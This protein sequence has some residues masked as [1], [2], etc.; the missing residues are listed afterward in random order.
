MATKADT[1]TTYSKAETNALVSG[2]TIPWLGASDGI[3][4]VTG[5]S[6]S[7]AIHTASDQ[8]AMEILGPGTSAEGDVI[9]YGKA[10]VAGTLTTGGTDVGATL[11]SQ[12]AG[13]AEVQQVAAN[14]LQEL[15]F[16]QSGLIEVQG[17]AAA[18][19]QELGFVQSGLS[20]VQG[21]VATH[22]TQIASL[23]TDLDAKQEA[24]EQPGAGHELL[25]GGSKLKRL[26]A[27]DGLLGG[28]VQQPD[29]SEAVTLTLAPSYK[30]GVQDQ[31]LA[32][33]ASIDFVT[34]N[35]QPAILAQA[36]LQLVDNVAGIPELSIDSAVLAGKQDVLVQEGFGHELLHDGN[37]LKKLQA[38]N[39][40]SAG[41]T[42]QPDGSLV[43][44]LTLASNYTNGVQE[45]LLGKQDTLSAGSDGFV[46]GE[47]TLLSG[48]TVKSLAPGAGI[49]LE[50]F[51]QHVRISA[52]L[53]QSPFWVAGSVRAS[54]QAVMNSKG[55][56]SFTA[57]RAP[58]FSTGVFLIDWSEPHP[59]G[60][61][62]MSIVS[63]E[64]GATGTG[65]Q[66]VGDI[67]S[68]SN[69]SLGNT[70][71]RLWVL[72]RNNVGGLVDGDFNFIVL[73]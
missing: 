31:L 19:L 38:Y 25:Y 32:Q 8:L 28:T 58:G 11:S 60:Q 26:Q 29:G 4:K 10:A 47:A 23:Q 37:K 66:A 1:E 16:V 48:N 39:G 56:Y 67:H 46:P 71:T 55:R 73:A 14:T 21:T 5:G 20:E 27:E 35:Y 17:V 51:G 12:G 15:G 22:R 7:L 9:V 34:A 45:Q 53:L 69:A 59:D 68:S 70:A 2:A 63:G 61:N 6:S 18:N 62:H 49:Q 13:L 65:W 24:L 3:H 30:Q 54:D 33:Q 72:T 40:I 52:P 42:T 43:L 44:D 41:T 57:S 50:D 64:A 36:P